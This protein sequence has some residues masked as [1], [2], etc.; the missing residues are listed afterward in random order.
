MQ[1]VQYTTPAPS[2]TVT[3]DTS[4]VGW[5]I[6]ATPSV[7]EVIDSQDKIPQK[8]SRIHGV[9]KVFLPPVQHKMFKGLQTVPQQF[10]I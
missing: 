1:G 5:E 2:V 4:I 9:L 8:P 6:I 10:I 7:Q 3:V